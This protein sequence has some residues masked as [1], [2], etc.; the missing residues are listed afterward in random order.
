[1]TGYSDRLNHAFAYAAKHHDRQV[2]KGARAPFR[3]WRSWC[4]AA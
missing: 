1:M 3:T 4:F 2:R